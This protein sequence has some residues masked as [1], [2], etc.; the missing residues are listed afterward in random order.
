M[1]SKWDDAAMQVAAFEEVSKKDDSFQFAYGALHLFT[2][3]H[4]LAIMS[5]RGDTDLSHLV[6]ELPPSDPYASSGCL[7][8]GSKDDNDDNDEETREYLLL[9]H[10]MTDWER[11]SLQQ[12]N[13]KTYLVMTWLT[14]LI[15]LRHVC[16]GGLAVP[17]PILSRSYQ[18]LS[19]GV[20]AFMQARKIK[21]TPFPFPY[22]QLVVAVLLVFTFT[23]PVVV[24]RYVKSIAFSTVLSVVATAASVALNE[25]AKEIE[26][27]YGFDANDLPLKSLHDQFVSRIS[28][29]T[30]KHDPEMFAD[31]LP[32][33]E[34]VD[35]YLEAREAAQPTAIA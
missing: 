31:V 7:P 20:G 5:L 29:L 11:E 34:L 13:N 22:A 18:V 6:P 1:S 35:A 19:D 32:P 23:A 21:E 10:K 26:D 4:G 17:P 24:A 14:R 25:V 15:T 27:P 12:C 9:L 2:L 8:C 30:H 33:K 16:E 3:M 28:S